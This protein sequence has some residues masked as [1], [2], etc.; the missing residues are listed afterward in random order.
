MKVMRNLTLSA[1]AL[2]ALAGSGLRTSALALEC[3]LPQHADGKLVMSADE[4]RSLGQRLSKDTSGNALPEA[5]ERL[6]SKDPKISDSKIVDVLTSAYCVGVAS[7]G[8]DDAA[9]KAKIRIFA[10]EAL[11]RLKK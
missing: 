11:D 1:L 7:E 2:G 8:L 6:R 5:A 3:P 4:T 10:K 9:A